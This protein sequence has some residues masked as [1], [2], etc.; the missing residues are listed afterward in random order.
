MVHILIVSLNARAFPF[1]DSSFVLLDLIEMIWLDESVL[2]PI[3]SAVIFPKFSR[4]HF[5]IVAYDR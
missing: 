3:I 5:G 2:H 4:L 1:V